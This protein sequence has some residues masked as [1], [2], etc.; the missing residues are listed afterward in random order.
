MCQ[1]VIDARNRLATA[2]LAAGLLLSALPAAAEPLGRLFF[3][4][5]RRAA[6]ER[7]RLLNIQEAQAQVIEGATLSVNGIVQRSSGKSTAW[8]N[9]MPQHDNASATG[10]IVDI[11]KNNPARSIVVAGEE[12]P[13]SLRVGE[14][15]NRATRETSS[16]VGD[17]HIVVKGISPVKAK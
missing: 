9:G 10:V 11:D 13:A 1:L 16:G 17:G 15:I 12:A 2:L 4:P 14:S 8:V 6:L 3:S 7:Q 5:E